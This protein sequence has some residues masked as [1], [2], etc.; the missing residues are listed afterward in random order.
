MYIFGG[1]DGADRLNDMWRINVASEQPAWERIE[2]VGRGR[3]ARV[4]RQ[5]WCLTHMYDAIVVKRPFGLNF[6]PPILRMDQCHPR[7]ATAPP[8]CLAMLPTSLA[9]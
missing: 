7:C 6:V 2:Q 3:R 1:F 4:D 8:P 9:A 5:A